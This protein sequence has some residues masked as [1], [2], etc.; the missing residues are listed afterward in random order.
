MKSALTAWIVSRSQKSSS[1]IASA[2]LRQVLN[3]VRR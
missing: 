2:I 3:I 1:G